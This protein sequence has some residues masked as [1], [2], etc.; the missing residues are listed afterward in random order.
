MD[1][2]SDNFPTVKLPRGPSYQF[3]SDNTRELMESLSDR[4][5]GCRSKKSLIVSPSLKAC[6][7]DELVKKEYKEM[8]RTFTFSQ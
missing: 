4:E 6:A 1:R 2:D 5:R 7:E 8:V 3:I